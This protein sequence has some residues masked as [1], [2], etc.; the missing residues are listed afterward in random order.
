VL[1]RATL[2]CSFG[3]LLGAAAT[4]GLAGCPS[5][6]TSTTYTPV[7]GIL[8]RSATL[9]AGHGCGTGPGQVYRYA[10]LLSYADE[11]GAPIGPPVYSGVFD[12]FADG[13]FSNLT[14]SDAGDYNFSVEIDAWDV[15]DFPSILACPTGAGTG[16]EPCP[17]DDPATVT[18]NLGTP[19]WTTSCLAAQYSGVSSLAACQPLVAG[20]GDAGTGDASTSDSG[21]SSDAAASGD[22]VAGEAGEAGNASDAGDAGNVSETGPDGGSDASGE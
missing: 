20:A 3:L 17:G 11:A 15:A 1:R 12:C 7:T 14:G 13:L 19:T 4:V 8:I 18:S 22:A 9:V 10:A 2:S 21:G 16:P 6:A 5:A